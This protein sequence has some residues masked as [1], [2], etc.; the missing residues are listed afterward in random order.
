[1]KIG[2]VGSGII[3][4]V[5]S[6]YLS[7]RGYEVDC[8]SPKLNTA[9]S[10][11]NKK[12]LK[13]VKYKKVIS[14]KYRRKDFLN[15][16]SISDAFLTKDME[17]FLGLEIVDEIG[18]A[19]YWGANLAVNGLKKDIDNLCL[20]NYEK[21]FINKIIPSINIQNFY[22]ENWDKIDNSAYK[23]FK[24]KEKFIDDFQLF[25]S[26]LAIY[27][28]DCQINNLPDERKNISIFGSDFKTPKSYN[29]IDGYVDFINIGE[30]KEKPKLSIKTSNSYF[31]NEYDYVVITCGAIGSFRLI[32]KSIKLKNKELIFSKLKHHPIIAIPCFV[33]KIKYPDKFISMSNFDVKLTTRHAEVYLNFFPL[34]GALKA[35]LRKV[36]YS[37]FEK[38]LIKVIKILNYLIRKLPDSPISP[39]WWIH[40]IYIASIYLPSKFTSSY[41]GYQ[42]NKIRIKGGFRS[43]FEKIV[44]KKLLPT[45]IL[46]LIRENIIP[47]TFKGKFV[48]NGA[49]YHYASSL[50]SFTDKNARLNLSNK[51][52]NRILIVDS[53]SSDFLPIANPTYYFICRA[54][55]LVRNIN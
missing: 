52:Y 35:Y 32:N 48:E 6:T 44:F 17:N 19:R 24:N 7:E 15:S 20:S 41:L 53:S 5:I 4:Y 9:K 49:D 42:D 39:T 8:I 36:N 30:P 27:K 28:E 47:L 38:A 10:F 43:D 29:K 21:T 13:N 18:L 45:I 31:I 11:I 37:R 55:K 51:K 3:G 16:K 34:I 1:M 26:I 33:P 46:K 14:P 2:V 40:R 54:I 22:E 25:S 23:S 50:K 12:D